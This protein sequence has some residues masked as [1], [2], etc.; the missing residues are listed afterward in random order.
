MVRFHCCACMQVFATV[1]DKC[2]ATVVVPLQTENS[3]FA[4]HT[5]NGIQS[6]SP[7]RPPELAPVW[8]LH[9]TTPSYVPCTSATHMFMQSMECLCSFRPVPCVT[10]GKVYDDPPDGLIWS[11]LC[12]I[13]V[14]YGSYI[15]RHSEGVITHIKD[16][17]MPVK[18]WTTA[19]RFLVGSRSG[20]P[21]LAGCLGA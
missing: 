6:V 4:S 17:G 15:Q 14:L 2:Y 3:A 10:E 21:R 12:C 19:S 20:G 13:Y 11:N 7:S 8:L 16:E 1:R 18:L 5:C 9:S